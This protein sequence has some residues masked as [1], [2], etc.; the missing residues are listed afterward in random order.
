[1]KF[2]QLS[3]DNSP[4]G[5]TLIEIIIS[6]TVV[7]IIAAMIAAYVGD[8]IGNITLPGRNLRDTLDIYSVMERM[9]LVYD[10]A[11]DMGIADLKTD[12]G[13]PAS[14][15]HA[16]S[17][18]TYNVIYNGYVQCDATATATFTADSSCNPASDSCILLV[19]ISDVDQSGIK[20]SKLFI[21]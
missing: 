16:N 20:V 4:S 2:I 15:P 3:R 13:Q 17:F 9:R 21:E 14:N 1:M 6:L 11:P 10:N 5:F 8:S 12:I 19:T 7:G 18:G